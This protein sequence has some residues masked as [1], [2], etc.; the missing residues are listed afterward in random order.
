MRIQDELFSPAGPRVGPGPEGFRYVADFVPEADEAALLAEIRRLDFQDVKMRGQVARRHLLRQFS[1]G[2]R[3][4]LSAFYLLF[5]S[6]SYC[7]LQSNSPKPN[8]A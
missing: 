6:G 4:G 1:R 8:Q 2:P 3:R 7:V 5:I